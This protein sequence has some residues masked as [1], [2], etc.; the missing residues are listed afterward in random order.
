MQSCFKAF[1]AGWSSIRQTLRQ[2][3]LGKE[4]QGICC[5]VPALPEGHNVTA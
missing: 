4:K 2:V 1:R 5:D 3:E